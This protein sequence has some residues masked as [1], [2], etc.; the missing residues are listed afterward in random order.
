MLTWTWKVENVLTDVDFVVFGDP[1]GTYGMRRTDTNEIIVPAGTAW[2]HDSAG[3]YTYDEAPLDLDPDVEYEYVVKSS[4]DDEL[5]YLHNLINAQDVP[6][7]VQRIIRFVAVQDG[8]AFNPDPAPVLSSPTGTYGVQRI[9]DSEIM[10]PDGAAFGV[11]GT[12]YAKAFTEDVDADATYRYYVEVL[13]RYIAATTNDVWSTML[14]IGRYTDSWEVE[15]MYNRENVRMWLSIPGGDDEDS[16]DFALRAWEFI[17]EAERQVDAEISG[18]F[19]NGDGLVSDFVNGV[20]PV[21]KNVATMLAGVMMYEARGVV[22]YDTNTSNVSHRLQ[23]HRKR[24]ERLMKSIRNG[25]IPIRNAGIIMG[26]P[27]GYA[28]C[29]VEKIIDDLGQVGSFRLL[30]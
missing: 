18:P 7:N 27:A 22:D 17:D 8:V 1:T 14:A 12:L 29:P 28:S 19:F 11:N 24:A 20:P 21:I 6:V 3:T 13:G 10:V 25:A 9:G 30:E 4:Y 23:W 15:K 5:T 26:L 16:V 2:T